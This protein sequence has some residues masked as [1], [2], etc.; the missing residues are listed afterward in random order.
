MIEF[1]EEHVE[2]VATLDAQGE[3]PYIDYWPDPLILIFDERWGFKCV[4]GIYD[5]KHFSLVQPTASSGMDIHELQAICFTVI[6]IPEPGTYYILT[7]EQKKELNDV[8][9]RVAAL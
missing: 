8:L 4:D 2:H 6:P 3:I 1:F 5:G 7:Q 9:N